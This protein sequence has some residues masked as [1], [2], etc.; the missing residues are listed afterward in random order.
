[1]SEGLALGACPG[2]AAETRLAEK[3]FRLGPA[4]PAHGSCTPLGKIL[5]CVNPHLKL[6]LLKSR[7]FK[8]VM[9]CNA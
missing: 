1:M 8:E 3:A 4:H 9:H 7:G 6:V 2:C 5:G